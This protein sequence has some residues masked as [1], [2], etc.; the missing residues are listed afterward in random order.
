MS[1]R[2]II[3]ELNLNWTGQRA[4]TVEI[5]KEVIIMELE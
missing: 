1:T 2:F 3:S 5:E 4:Q